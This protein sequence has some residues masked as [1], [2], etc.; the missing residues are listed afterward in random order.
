MKYFGIIH[1]NFGAKNR[2]IPRI[3]VSKT[4]SQFDI[5]G[6]KI[7]TYLKISI[8]E[9]KGMFYFWRENSNINK[10]LKI[11]IFGVKIQNRDFLMIW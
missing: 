6:A 2:R 7:Q 3:C 9:W 8:K 4:I 1:L 11:A 5:F 10:K